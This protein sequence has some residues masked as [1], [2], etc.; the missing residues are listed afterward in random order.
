M[1]TTH[2]RITDF[3]THWW[4]YFQCESVQELDWSVISLGPIAATLCVCTNIVACRRSICVI[5]SSFLVIMREGDDSHDS[6]ECV[7][8]WRSPICVSAFG[9]IEPVSVRVS[10]PV[11]VSMSWTYSIRPDGSV[12]ACFP[13]HSVSPWLVHLVQKGLHKLMIY[14]ER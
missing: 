9:S 7:L 12:S 11:P 3:M 10:V 5:M 1:R 2:C 13:P 8:I 4:G 6:L 14:I